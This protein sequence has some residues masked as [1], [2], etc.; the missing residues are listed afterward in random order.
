[1]AQEARRLLPAKEAPRRLELSPAKP[2][3]RRRNVACRHCRKLHVKCVGSPCCNACNK[4]GIRCEPHPDRR[5]KERL[6]DVEAKLNDAEAKRRDAEA[7]LHD[8][9]AKR[10]DAEAKLRDAEAKLRDA[11]AKLHD[12]EA[13]LRDAEAK[14][15]DAEAK[16]RDAELLYEIYKPTGQMMSV[17]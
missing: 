8:A 7:K 6:H 11:E 1:M 3:M 5:R 16:R 14:V 9:E 12:A 4:L 2:R 13:K 17:I 15:H 10:R